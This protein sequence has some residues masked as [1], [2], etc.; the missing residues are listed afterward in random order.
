MRICHAIKNLK[1]WDRN[2][3]ENNDYYNI[4]KD[5]KNDSFNRFHRGKLK[6]RFVTL[7]YLFT[8]HEE[9][10]SKKNSLCQQKSFLEYKNGSFHC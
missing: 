2:F 6:K 5:R 4:I 9:A 3:I 10:V 7:K 8:L 1:K